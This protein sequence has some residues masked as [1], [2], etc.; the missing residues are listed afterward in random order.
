[1]Q[2]SI[3]NLAAIGLIALLVT[4]GAKAQIPVTDVAAITQLIMQIER[5]EEEILVAR[6]TLTQA[7]DAYTAMTGQRGMERLLDG[8]VRNYLPPDWQEL[9]RAIRGASSAYSA[10][11]H[12]VERLV[13]DNAVLADDA[14]AAFTPEDRSEIEAARRTA[15]MLQALSNQSLETT[16]ARFDSIQELIG[17]IAR[18]DDP[19][20][21]AELQARIGA[22][23]GMLQNEANKLHILNQ[24]LQA[25]EWTRQQ[26]ERE[27][28][29]AGVGRFRDLPPLGLATE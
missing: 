26:R 14:L 28:A 8:T 10:L 20:A 19:K 25:Q 9:E 6:D 1:M 24:S 3:L 15:A 29:I 18:A 11:A 5:L 16:S 7:Q 4:P 17:A 27:R 22:E 12:D 21:I 2:P 13:N 23:Q